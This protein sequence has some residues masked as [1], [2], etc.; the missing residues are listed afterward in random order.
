MVLVQLAGGLGNQMFE[1]AAGRAVAI[2]NGQPLVLDA[3]TAMSQDKLF[4]RSLELGVFQVRGR[5]AAD[6]DREKLFSTPAPYRVRWAVDM[7][8]RAVPVVASGLPVW[9]LTTIEE[10]AEFMYEPAVEER[11]NTHVWLRGY[12][13]HDGYVRGIRPLLLK[14]F[15]LREPLGGRAAGLAREM[16]SSESLAVHVRRKF[17][18]G[19]GRYDNQTDEKHGVLPNS[20]Y[21]QAWEQVQ[22]QGIDHVYVFGDDLEWARSSLKFPVPVTYVEGNKNYEDLVLISKCKHQII[23]NSSFAWWGA[24]LNQNPVKVVVAPRS[25]MAEAGDTSSMYPRE[26]VV[27]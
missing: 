25:F 17:G 19:V 15:S 1:Y 18:D 2:R 3:R 8:R 23:A 7:L 10:H 20:Y 14:E 27:V 4:Q 16:A 21:E 12:F 24:W 6:S 26:W 5:L 22:A 11:Y 13:Q 9:G